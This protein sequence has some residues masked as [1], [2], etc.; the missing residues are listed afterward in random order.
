M[1]DFYIT[2]V[3]DVICNMIAI[4]KQFHPSPDPLQAPI[5]DQSESRGNKM[6]CKLFCPLFLPI[7]LYCR[8]TLMFL[9]LTA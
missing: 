5:A 3:L 4:Q 9:T 2:A 6:K 7:S 1:C 8:N